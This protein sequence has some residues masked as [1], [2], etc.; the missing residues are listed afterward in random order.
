MTDFVADTPSV[1]EEVDALATPDLAAPDWPSAPANIAPDVVV[2]VVCPSCGT[3]ARVN[4]TRREA[5]DFCVQCEYPLFWAVE[6]PAPSLSSLGADTGLRRLP[7]TAGRAVLAFLN[8]PV[9]TEPNPPA[10]VHCARCGS[11][12]R[13]AEVAVAPEPEPEP[14]V[15]QVVEAPGRNWWLIGLAAA[16]VLALLV[17]IA[18]LGLDAS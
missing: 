6:R 9:C 11:E 8:C 3:P 2:E 14:V 12:L 1:D 7:G 17:L 15:E 18:V 10:A 4:T 16:V 13:P 5:D